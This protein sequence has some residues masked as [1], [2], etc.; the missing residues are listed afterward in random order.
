MKI[1]YRIFIL[2]FT[3]IFLNSCKDELYEDN[4]MVGLWKQVSVSEDGSAIT[5]TPEQQS[6]KLLIDANGAYRIYSQSFQAYNNGNG[7]TSFF[8]TWSVLDGKWANFST[9]KWQFIPTLSTDS[10]KVNITYFKDGNNIITG[11]DSLS[12][13][14]KQW[15]R[16]HEQFRFTILKL[17]AT[18]ME[19]RIKTFEGEKKYALLFS[20]SPSDFFEIKPYVPGKVNYIPKFVNDQNYWTIRKEFQTLKTYIFKFQKETY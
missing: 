7:P 6:C 11:I 5:L 16:Y 15:T 3:I 1:T 13:V 18:E 2:L 10:N 12:T 20:P 9:E 4:L 8:G 17:T 19:I 14:Q